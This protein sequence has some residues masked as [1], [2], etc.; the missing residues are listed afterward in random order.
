MRN[1]FWASIGINLLVI[2]LLKVF[3]ILPYW[4]FGLG[5]TPQLIMEFSLP[6][7]VVGQIVAAIIWSR[8]IK[9]NVLIGILPVIIPLWYY[10]DMVRPIII[11]Y[12]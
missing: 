3:V 5:R 6:S 12:M 11:A 4:Y 2:F 10:F 7:I 1:F 9:G 8:K